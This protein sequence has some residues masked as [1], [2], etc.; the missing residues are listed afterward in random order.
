MGGRSP[1][2]RRVR[3]RSLIGVVGLD[4]A[5]FRLACAEVV[6]LGAVRLDF[7]GTGMAFAVDPNPALREACDAI[8][9]LA[10]GV[11]AIDTL[12]F[13]PMGSERMA[14]GFA[15]LPGALGR[16][17]DAHLG[18]HS[19]VGTR[20][21]A[22]VGSGATAACAVAALVQHRYRVLVAAE[23]PGL[24]VSAAHRMNVDVDLVAPAA[25]AGQRLDL[26]V[27]TVPGR[28]QAV[29]SAVVDVAGAWSGADGRVIAAREVN[30]RQRQDQIRVL[31][32]K[33]VGVEAIL[34]I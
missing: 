23:V 18:V 4:P 30:A 2:F 7:P 11:G 3:E 13:Q 8:D 1:G 22:I 29:P 20:L 32:G 12:V 27:Q 5:P 25:L 14:V 10:K 9:G 26:L 21:A 33:N 24:A 19:G 16:T 28:V 17:L 31:T 15:A 34:E 6:E